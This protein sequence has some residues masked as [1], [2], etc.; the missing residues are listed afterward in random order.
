[1]TSEPLQPTRLTETV[2]CRNCGQVNATTSNF[3]I[4]CGASLKGVREEAVADEAEST[5]GADAAVSRPEGGE[6]DP[7]AAGAADAARAA[8]DER[9]GRGGSMDESS[10]SEVEAERRRGTR[11]L[12]LTPDLERVWVTHL[13]ASDVRSRHALRDRFVIGREEGDLRIPDDAYLSGRHASIRREG[14]AYLLLDLDSTNGTYIRIREQVRLEPGDWLMVGEQTF[15]FE[16]LEGSPASAGGA[17][18]RT[19]LLRGSGATMGRLVRLGEGGRELAVYP[20]RP[21]RTLIGRDRGDLKFPDDELLSGEHASI[22][23]PDDPSA[24]E[25]FILADEGSRNGVFLRIRSEWPLQL[26]DLF[27]AGRQAFRLEEQPV[28]EG[29]RK[30]Q[31]VPRS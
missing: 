2:A 14:S 24:D 29:A 3:C 26:G 5:A 12:A 11:P 25:P 22:M 18:G 19:R 23:A 27:V 31:S 13:D 1:M 9:T 30:P 15:R 10:G 20:L 16:R 28:D 4:E 17:S 8:V 21:G 7:A 6:A